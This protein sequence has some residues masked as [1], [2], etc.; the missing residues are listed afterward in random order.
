VRRRRG[1]G[2]GTVARSCIACGADLEESMTGRGTSPGSD[3]RKATGAVAT[4][5]WGPRRDSFSGYRAGVGHVGS[6][7]EG[8]AGD[9]PSFP[10]GSVQPAERRTIRSVKRN[11]DP[12]PRQ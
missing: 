11:A 4:V 6:D 3:R 8:A 5:R 7:S 9:R 12:L 1:P 10:S 2:R